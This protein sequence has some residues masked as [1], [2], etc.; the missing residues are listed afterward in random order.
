MN[1]RLQ[2]LPLIIMPV[3]ACAALLMLCADGLRLAA[4]AHAQQTAN[5]A[6]GSTE[7]AA[8]YCWS[9][10]VLVLIRQIVH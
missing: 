10:A 5:R 4:Q 3:L 7:Q 9:L 8:Q 2:F 1:L 6:T